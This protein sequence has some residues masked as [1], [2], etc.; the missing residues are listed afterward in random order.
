MIKRLL[1]ANRGEIALRI[2][3]AC[4]QLGIETVAIYAKDDDDSLHCRLA[5]QAV[6]IG[7]AGAQS[8]MNPT[9][10]LSACNIS[11]ADA[12]HPGYGFLSENAEFAKDNGEY[13]YKSYEK[14]IDDDPQDDSEYQE[15]PMENANPTATLEGVADE[16]KA[17]D[18]ARRKKKSKKSKKS[19]KC[20]WSLFFKN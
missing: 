9:A 14:K 4:Q 18:K 6:C 8:Y 3:R 17:E 12:V 1:I 11:G 20:L 7:P 15:T 19:K 16:D 2:I 13:E 5:D 10:I